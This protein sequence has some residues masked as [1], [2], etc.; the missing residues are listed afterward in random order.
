[1]F[2]WNRMPSVD[3]FKEISVEH[4]MDTMKQLQEDAAKCMLRI[5]YED[6]YSDDVF[7]SLEEALLKG[8]GTV[9]Y[10]VTKKIVWIGKTEEP[11]NENNDAGFGY[12]WPQSR[13]VSGKVYG[14]AYDQHY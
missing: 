2:S 1:M 8:R 11:V 12:K 7:H 10:E 9:I 14:V 13:V 6:D 5:T 3:P 4:N